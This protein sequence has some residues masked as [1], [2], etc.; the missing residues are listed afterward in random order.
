MVDSARVQTILVNLIQNSIKFSKND[1]KI[2]V[3]LSEFP[4]DN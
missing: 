4:T 3:K 1:E 2:I